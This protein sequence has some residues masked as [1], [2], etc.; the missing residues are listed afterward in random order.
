MKPGQA[1]DLAWVE[2]EELHLFMNHFKEAKVIYTTT[3]VEEGRGRFD[4]LKVFLEGAG[5]C[6]LTHWYVENQ[7]GNAVFLRKD[8][9]DATM[10][11]LIYVP[12]PG[13]SVC[14]PP[15]DL[16]CF[17]RKVGGKSEEHRMEGIDFIYMI[18]LDERPEK[19][20]LASKELQLYGINPYRFSAVNGWKLPTAILE[21]VGAKFYP[22]ILM[23]K[24]MGHTFK[25]IDGQQVM[26]SEFLQENGCSYFIRGITKGPIGIV[27]SHLSVLQDAY[28][29]GYETVWVMEDDVEA[30][31]DP[32]EI[33]DLIRKLDRLDDWDILFTDVDTKDPKGKAVPCR[34]LAA[35]PNV[36]VEPL[37]QFLEKFCAVGNDFNRIGMRY[38]AYSMIVRRSGMKKILDYYRK[39]RIFIPYDM[40]FWLC[41]NLKMYTPRKD[42]VSH[43]MNAPS[44][45]L[46]PKYEECSSVFQ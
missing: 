23:D 40:D 14:Y 39:Y 10:R 29:S 2:E 22:G 21:Q 3:C 9:Y 18:N 42:I 15:I 30:L 43:R 19:F 16:E 20:E 6:F 12:P 4:Q 44:D 17:L 32:R 5:F 28:D 8:I 27:L 37:A 38:G 45:N 35:R 13:N 25:E 7:R 26:H 46:Q 34:A 11:T 24:Y 1:C 36:P 31:S 41:S 33:P